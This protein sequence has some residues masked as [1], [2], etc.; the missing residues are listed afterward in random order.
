M[1]LVG[2]RAIR[3][4]CS[5]FRNPVDWDFVASRDEALQLF[6]QHRSSIAGFVP[7]KIGTK[8]QCRLT[9]GTRVELELQEEVPSAQV[10]ASLPMD[11][12]PVELLGSMVVR[13]PSLSTLLLLKKSHLIIPAHWWKNIADYHWLKGRV[14]QSSTIEEL[15]FYDLRRK[16]AEARSKR[17]INLN[18][19]NE[20]F[21][22]KSQKS[23]SRVYDH[24]S[25]H[26]SICFYDEPLHNRMRPD[27]KKAATSLKLFRKMPHLDQIRAVQE[28]A[29]VIA[30]E[31]IIIPALQTSVI[32][33]ADTIE[34]AYRW[35]IMRI[36]TT[37]TK[38]WFRDFAIEH[39]PEVVSLHGYD[40]VTKFRQS[41]ELRAHE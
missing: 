38:G 37:L 33:T 3:L 21:F 31:R 27:P 28:E 25:I 14:E 36:S 39:H 23:V 35:A 26:H 13:L 29:M 41:Q 34:T 11:E 1:I 24:D 9:D 17:R 16:E 19:S 15:R 32:L 8:Y 22:D 5:E 7:N 12:V 18:M 30:L 4:H 20:A 2:S 40:F 10:L 6:R